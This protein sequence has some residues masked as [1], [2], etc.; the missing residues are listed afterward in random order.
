MGS[1]SEVANRLNVEW[2]QPWYNE[3]GFDTTTVSPHTPDMAT[4]YRIEWSTNKD[5]TNS[6]YY[7]M[8][9]ITG[10]GDDVKC[11]QTTLETNPCNYVIGQSVQNVTIAS[12]N[13]D[14]LDAGTFRLVYV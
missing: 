2:T 6:T 12:G 3:L 11:E 14:P 4:H 9:T 8:R 1:T 13:G 7:N 5:F 10:D